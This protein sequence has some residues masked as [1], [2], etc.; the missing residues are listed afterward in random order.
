MPTDNDKG[1]R[2]DK[3]DKEKKPKKQEP[4][5][6]D[7]C[8]RWQQQGSGHTVDAVSFT[9]RNLSQQRMMFLR[10]G[11]PWDDFEL[12]DPTAPL[13]IQ[14]VLEARINAAPVGQARAYEGRW[15][16]DCP[17]GCGGAECVDLAHPIFMCCS[18]WNANYDHQWLK[19]QLPEEGKRRWI[20]RLLL[21]RPGN[22]RNWQ[23]HE[24]ITDAMVENIARGVGV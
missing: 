23:P 13:E 15:I 18:C 24:S 8:S 9:L 2:D 19:V 5:I 14:P 17:G 22:A 12:G 6:L 7:L 10:A 11:A 4:A 21:K 16:A 3:D 20:E 1:I